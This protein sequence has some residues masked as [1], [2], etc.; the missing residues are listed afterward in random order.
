MHQLLAVAAFH[1]A[2]SLQADLEQRRQYSLRALKHQ[3]EGASILR[4]RLGRLTPENSHTCLE[5]ATLLTIGSFAAKSDAQ[6]R[7]NDLISIFFSCRGLLAISRS[8]MDTLREGP[9]REKFTAGKY[10]RDAPALRKVCEILYGLSGR[11]GEVHKVATA[12][13]DNP[14]DI[15]QTEIYR[16]IRIIHEA[17]ETAFAPPEWRVVLLWPMTFSDTFIDLLSQKD[18]LALV[19]IAHFCAIVHLTEPFAWWVKG[20]GPSVLQDVQWHL[21]GSCYESLLQWPLRSAG[22]SAALT[23]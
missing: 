12:R 6:P 3:T 7:L 16:L 4:Y 5:T 23:V 8:A 1:K 10:T 19:L 22:P 20:W 13:D 2:S 9:L 14:L 11:L 18:H 15:V 21:A 17:V